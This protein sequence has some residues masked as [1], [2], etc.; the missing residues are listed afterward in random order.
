MIYKSMGCSQMFS[1]CCRVVWDWNTGQIITNGPM[2]NPH[3]IQY[4]TEHGGSRPR[5]IGDV[6]CG[7][8]PD[9]YHLREHVRSL[10]LKSRNVDGNKSNIVHFT[11]WMTDFHEVVRARYIV[12]DMDQNLDLRIRYMA[13]ELDATQFKRLLQQREKARNK[14]REIEQVIA[15][16]YSVSGDILREILNQTTKTGVQAQVEQLKGLL[17]FA[18]EGM[19]QISKRYNCT[20]PPISVAFSLQG[21][22]G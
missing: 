12:H 13:N 22:I 14:N 19:K 7:G 4:I 16:A 1:T 11:W 21:T 2:H 3:Y 9:V 20:T 8:L 10:G 6:P 15:M 18:E 17:N 5:A